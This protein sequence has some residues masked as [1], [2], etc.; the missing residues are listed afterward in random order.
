MKV[1]IAQPM[2][3]MTL[4]EIIRQRREA[5]QEISIAENKSK[6]EVVNKLDANFD[7]G[8]VYNLGKSIM[9]MADAEVVYFLPG[10]DKHKGCMI[11]RTVAEYY[12]LEIED[13]EDNGDGGFVVRSGQ[14]HI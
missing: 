1:Y 14:A 2:S 3:G 9:R 12:E 4:E 10:W 5:T 6:I 13:V 7:K 11:E 8:P